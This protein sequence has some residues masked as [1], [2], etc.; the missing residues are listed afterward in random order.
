MNGAIHSATK[1]SNNWKF[2]KLKNASP[3][4][5]AFLHTLHFIKRQKFDLRSQR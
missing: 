5:E 4:G 3:Y 2:I 1:H